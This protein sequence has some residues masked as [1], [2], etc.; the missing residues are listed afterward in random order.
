MWPNP[1]EIVNGKLY[2]LC[3]VEWLTGK[4]PCFEIIEQFLEIMTIAN[5][6]HDV[7]RIYTCSEPDFRIC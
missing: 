3:S 1:Q 6:Q 4:R 2:F 5:L 7:S